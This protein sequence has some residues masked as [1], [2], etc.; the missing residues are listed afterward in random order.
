MWKLRAMN[1][2]YVRA[3]DQCITREHGKLYLNIK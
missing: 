2:D 1:I 3:H